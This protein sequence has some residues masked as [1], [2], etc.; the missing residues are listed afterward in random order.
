MGLFSRKN[1]EQ[2]EERSVNLGALMFNSSS[3]FSE[4]AAMKLSA[5]YCGVNQIS[6]ALA[7]LPVNVVKYDFDEKQP[8]DHPLW[9][10]LNITP[11]GTNNHFNSFKAAV[12]SVIIKGNGYF[13]IDRD[14]KLNVKAI[15]YINA[16][17]VTPMPQPN[18]TIKY[19]VQGFPAAVEGSDM[20][21]LYTHCDEMHNGIS[22]LKYAYQVLMGA[23]NADETADKFYRSG[24]GLNGI[25]KA[26][27][28][29][30]NEQ[31]KQIRESWNQAFNEG[32]N[33]V[34]V[35]PQ[36]LDYQPVSVSPEDAQLLESREF[37]IQEIA[38]FLNISPIK[39]FQLKEVSYNSLE[40]TQLSFLYDTVAPYIQLFIEEFNRKLFKPSEVGKLGVMFD[41]TAAMQTNRKDLGEYY[42]MMLTNGIMSIDEIRGQM[43]L[44]KL[45]SEGSDSHWVQLSYQTIENI[46]SGKVLKSQD[47]NQEEQDPNQS[48][49]VKE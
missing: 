26:Q 3:S 36:G 33:G 47:G 48:K 29:L 25:I 43:G 14:S 23:R 16:D 28:T 4:S 9:K 44:P 13:Y 15:R 10:I 5:F 17:F 20:I 7:L 30:T 1:K 39:L 32:G 46:A 38:R 31:K 41:Y 12:E 45:N 37:N 11:D 18:G 40:A 27:A 2:Q 8:I 24:A 35:L 6:N 21:H 22:L 42:R 19:I 49:T 34:A